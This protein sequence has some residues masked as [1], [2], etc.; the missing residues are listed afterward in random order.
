MPSLPATEISTGAVDGVVNQASRTAVRSPEGRWARLRVAASRRPSLLTI[1][2]QTVVSGVSFLTTV[3]VGRLA[4]AEELGIYALG[5]SLVLAAGHLQESLVSLPYTIFGNRV[6][7]RARAIQ[8]G[9]AWT[10]HLGIAALAVV[11]LASS[12]LYLSTTSAGGLTA[13]V[14]MLTAAVPFILL[15][16]FARR[17]AF[18][19]M[20]MDRALRLDVAVGGVQLL[21]L[22]GL[23]VVGQLS[24]MT[25][26]LAIGLACASV[27]IAWRQRN[28]AR[29]IRRWGAART[30][31]PTHWRFGRWAMATRL[32]DMVNSEY[33]LLWLLAFLAGDAQA[34]ALAMCMTVVLFSNPFVMGVAHAL[35]PSAARAFTGGGRSVRRVVWRATR[36][37]GAAMAV[38]T[39]VVW[40]FGGDLLGL[41]YGAAFAGYAPA[42]V[43]LTLYVTTSAIGLGPHEGL[44]AI[45]RP[46]V[47]FKLSLLGTGV[48][49]AAASWLVVPL[50]VLGAAYSLLIAA[51][52]ETVARV[53]AFYY[54]THSDRPDMGGVAA[55]PPVA[56]DGGDLDLAS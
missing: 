21:I 36:L 31:V 16:D 44:H 50:G 24:A 38:F 35:T 19:D 7:G 4:G 1:A 43:V 10:H 55:R 46:D 39:A 41:L 25:A 15:R 23:A 30:A 53:G 26:W 8:A 2:D 54:L 9:T 6:E 14:W 13:V 49:V 34:G 32:V 18:A 11:A 5:G 40:W 45:G 52:V 42:A 22:G 28:G 37:L 17:L 27:G 33:L 29:L 51:V 20:N 48:M 3:L 47:N 12:A 56:I